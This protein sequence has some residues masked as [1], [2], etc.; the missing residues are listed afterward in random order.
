MEKRIHPAPG[1][2]QLL[3]RPVTCT[4]YLH[5]LLQDSGIR[6]YT[7]LVTTALPVV[8]HELSRGL[9]RWPCRA[10]NI[11]VSNSIGSALGS[12]LAQFAREDTLSHWQQLRL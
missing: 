8:R 11:L 2:T 6:P 7:Q 4:C 9:T 1:S 10:A 3:C 12:L 5:L